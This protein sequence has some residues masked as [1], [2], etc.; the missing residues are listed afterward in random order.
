MRDN[1]LEGINEDTELVNSGTFE[2]KSKEK[3]QLS[4]EEFVR[5]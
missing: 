4:E 5:Y 1:L 2:V 3:R